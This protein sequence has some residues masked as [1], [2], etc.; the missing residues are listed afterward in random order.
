MSDTMQMEPLAPEAGD[1]PQDGRRRLVIGAVVGGAVLL[2]LG[3]MYLLLFSGGSEEVAVTVTPGAAPTAA[4]TPAPGGNKAPKENNDNL[5]RNPFQPLAAEA[6]PAPA[7][8]DA[9]APAGSPTP[10]TASVSGMYQLKVVSVDSGR[11]L[12]TLTVDDVTYKNQGPN[13]AVPTSADVQILVAGF[14]S[15]VRGDYV[16]LQLGSAPANKYYEG[17]TGSFTWGTG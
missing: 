12:A 2:V 8:T 9:A 5:G 6:T 14:G 10:G 11:K 4:A 16:E 3:A 17:D 7:P 1:A 15:D 13:D